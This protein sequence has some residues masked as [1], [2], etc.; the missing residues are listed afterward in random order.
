MPPYL[1]EPYAFETLL[2]WLADPSVGRTSETLKQRGNACYFED[3]LKHLDVVS[4]IQEIEYVD[5]DYMNDFAAYYA[6]CFSS[7]SKFTRRIHFF[8]IQIGRDEFSTALSD[9]ASPLRQ[10][11]HDDPDLYLG[12]IVVKPLPRTFIGKT[13]L[14]PYPEEKGRRYYPIMKQYKANLFGLD[15]SLDSLAF[16]EQDH[17]VAACATSALWS[18]FHGSS[19]RF[20]HKIPSPHA[21]TLA[22]TTNIPD[23]LN[24]NPDT[25]RFPNSGLSPAQISAAIRSL[26]LEAFLVACLGKSANGKAESKLSR[27]T[28]VNIAAYAYL[29]SGIPVL[30]VCKL[31]EKDA[32]GITKDLGY[33]AITLT[34]FS[35]DTSQK[36][37]PVIQ[38]GSSEITLRPMRIRGFYAHD[39]QIGPFARMEWKDD[40]TLSTSWYCLEKR[41][42]EAAPD[43]LIIPL[44]SKIR[45]PYDIVETAIVEINQLIHLFAIQRAGKPVEWEIR[46]DTVNKLKSEIIS[47]P[48]INP[49][50]RS[51][52]LTRHMPKHIWRA[53]A[54]VDSSQGTP[55]GAL[56]IL[57]DATALQQ[58]GGLVDVL[59]RGDFLAN[60]IVG[61]LQQPKVSAGS[62][63]AR[64]LEL[65]QQ[66]CLFFGCAVTQQEKGPGSN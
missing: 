56:E 55:R 60:A 20:G 62:K 35:M 23:W 1:L 50:E 52:L 12:F 66:I 28:I 3:Y 39:D 19:V 59:M 8:A 41:L 2:D 43:S 31:K 33:H 51:R 14:R 17:E 48:D 64:L 26:D 10:R 18:L 54:W 47:D 5:S 61:S 13:C 38:V 21:I 29:V 37:Q 4:M 32:K 9:P 24:V 58:E 44:A 34:G 53:I 25:R 65:T 16:Q 46:L 45:I 36:L 63:N 30:M 22:A 11:L 57:V 15:L 40:N 7:F 6:K 27:R 49:E 42:V